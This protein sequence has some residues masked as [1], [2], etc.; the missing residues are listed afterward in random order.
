MKLPKDPKNKQT[1]N[2]TA[3][4]DPAVAK[5][6]RQQDDLRLAVG[7]LDTDKLTEV[8]PYKSFV[9]LVSLTRSEIQKQRKFSMPVRQLMAELGVEHNNYK[10]LEE[11][12][13]ALM[14][15]IVNFN[16]HKQDKNPGWN[17]AQILG[18]SRLEDGQI[19]FEFTEPVWE[20]LKDPIVYAYITR[21]GTYSFTSKHEIALYNWLTCMLVPSYKE[22]Y[23]FES[24]DYLL[25]EVLYINPQETSTYNRFKYLN[26]KILAKSIEKINRLTGLEVTY[27]GLKQ[28]DDEQLKSLIRS[29][30]K[31]VTHLKQPTKSRKISYIALNVRLKVG[32]T[33]VAESTPFS[34]EIKKVLYLLSQ[35]G[36][37][38]DQ[39]IE[40][41][42]RELIAEHG[43]AYC[44]KS[45]K[46]ILKDYKPIKARLRNP[47]GYLRTKLLQQSMLELDDRADEK[48]DGNDLVA[49]YAELLKTSAEAIANQQEISQFIIYLR[50]NYAEH[51]AT[52]KTLMQENPALR[53]AARNLSPDDPVLFLA[54]PSLNSLLYGF[55][56]RFAYK[57]SV[58]DTQQVMAMQLEEVI[59]RVRNHTPPEQLL[60]LREQ[61]AA[62]GMKL[63]EVEAL[64]IDLLSEQS[65]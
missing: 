3:L 46:Q 41:H 50:A 32:E 38:L 60:R 6:S 51:L 12:I 4:L 57:T 25:K 21:K 29:G 30:K 43:E 24:L 19:E 16:V 7:F 58:S 35:E 65:Q 61:A 13:D 8:A 28:I 5:G 63:N 34:A 2:L 52:L 15:T 59:K 37:V 1:E 31:V 22:V 36:L 27:E 11:T 45:I 18:P 20:K 53:A 49:Q 9:A 17:K 42:L 26:Q 44:L 64:A 47:G 40:Q 48:L 33:L 23:C 54:K 14:S 39:K 10:R 55:R 62:Q 56:E